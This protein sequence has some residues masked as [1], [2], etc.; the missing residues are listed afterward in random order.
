M[1]IQ[2]GTARTI[3]PSVKFRNIGDKVVIGVVDM[4]E[5]PWLEYGTQTPKIGK[6]GKPRTQVR[7]TGI[8]V[9]GNAAIS[10]TDGD[11]EVKP[12]EVVSIFCAAHNRWEF[13]EA[14]KRLGR[15]LNVGDVMQVRYDRDEKGLSVNAKKVRT[16][17]IRAAKA[18]EADLV[19]H[20]EEQYRIQRDGATAATPAQTTAGSSDEF[21]EPF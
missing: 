1:G 6:D 21:D 8:V 12:G 10:D 15:P 16:V 14:T 3:T 18:D 19:R 20:C 13:I 2:L 7:L 11:R 5:V 4:A 9:S 17:S